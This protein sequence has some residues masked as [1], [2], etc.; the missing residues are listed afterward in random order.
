MKD[1]ADSGSSVDGMHARTYM[2]REANTEQTNLQ[3][4]PSPNQVHLLDAAAPKSGQGVLTDVSALQQLERG[5]SEF[6]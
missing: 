4:P 2:H 6:V 3:W 5:L 1:A